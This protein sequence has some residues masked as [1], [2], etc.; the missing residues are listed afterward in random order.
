MTA[1][2]D[3][4]HRVMPEE[5]DELGHAANYHYVRWLQDA[6]VAHSAAVGW[7]SERYRQ[8]GAGW[9][10]RSHQITYLKPALA[11]D[12]LQIRTWVANMKPVLSLRRYEIRNPR[13]DLLAK[14][15]TNW[16]FIRYETQKPQRIPPQVATSF[17][18]PAA[19]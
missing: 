17:E 4:P 15:E 9:V 11:G 7:P 12:Q 18:P 13:G 5:I 1:F 10:V 16:A 6:A 3:H 2:F 14:A 19:P 8:L